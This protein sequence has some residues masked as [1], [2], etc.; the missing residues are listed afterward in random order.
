LHGGSDPAL[1]AELVEAYPE[2]KTT[3]PGDVGKVS[4]M[5]AGANLFL[6]TAPA[7]IPL[8]VALQVY[9]LALLGNTEPT[10]I[11]PA[12]DKFVAIQSSTGAIAD[13]P[14]SQVLTKIW[15]G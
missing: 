3:Q 7:L 14:A 13:I 1:I 4:A 11:F 5:L 9:T 15:G 10:Q 6:C 8:A 12:S 2:L